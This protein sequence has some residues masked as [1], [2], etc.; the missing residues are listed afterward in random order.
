M[1]LLQLEDLGCAN[2][3]PAIFHLLRQQALQL[4]VLQRERKVHLETICSLRANLV[5][6]EGAQSDLHRQAD[7]LKQKIVDLEQHAQR[8]VSGSI[9]A[10]G[11]SGTAI[12]HAAPSLPA[13]QGAASSGGSLG[14]GAAPGSWAALQRLQRLQPEAPASDAAPS[15][16]A[17]GEPV[18]SDEGASDAGGYSTSTLDLLCTAAHFGHIGST[19]PDA[20]KA[21][22]LV[23]PESLPSSLSTVSHGGTSTDAARGRRKRSIGEVEGG[24]D[25]VPA[26]SSASV[27]A[28]GGMGNELAIERLGAAGSL[29]RIRQQAAARG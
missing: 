13:T 2:L 26:T 22:S 27:A 6:S 5:M 23:R 10:S 17:K 9:P 29:A 7:A 21:S 20:A 19:E 8:M 24:A 18:L 12:E 3:P 15:C 14:G 11:A 16:C 25:L 28:V 4:I 1:S